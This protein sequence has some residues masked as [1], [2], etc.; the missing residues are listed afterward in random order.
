MATNEP[1]PSLD[2]FLETADAS[3]LPPSRPHVSGLIKG[4]LP[5]GRTFTERE[6]EM[7]NA[8]FDPKNMPGKWPD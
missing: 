2:E 6:A 7:A 8:I 5:R 1:H 4:P 3:G